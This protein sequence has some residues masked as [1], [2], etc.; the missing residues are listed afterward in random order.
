[1]SPPSTSK[2]YIFPPL[3]NADILQCLADLQLNF[4]EDDLNKPNP[5]R[6]ALLYEQV[7]EIMTGVTR[8]HL[9]LHNFAA[10][11]SSEYP[12]CHQDSLSQLALFRHLYVACRTLLTYI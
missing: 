6:T 9:E 1:M 12:E 10:I 5:A 2:S 3:P 11:E 7:L 4:S 8:D